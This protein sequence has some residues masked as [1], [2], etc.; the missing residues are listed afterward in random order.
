MINNSLVSLV[1]HNLQDMYIKTMKMQS[2]ILSYTLLSLTKPSLLFYS[3]L[4][5]YASPTSFAYKVVSYNNLLARLKHSLYLATITIHHFFLKNTYIGEQ[6]TSYQY[7]FILKHFSSSIKHLKHSHFLTNPTYLLVS[8]SINGRIFFIFCVLY[9]ALLHL[10]P[11]RFHSVGR[12]WHW[13]SDALTTRLYL[14]HLRT[15]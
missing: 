1:N 12:C 13:Q 2:I 3:R 14:I 9:S 15:L 8:L 11:L 7:C 5:L 10:P 4:S 6:S